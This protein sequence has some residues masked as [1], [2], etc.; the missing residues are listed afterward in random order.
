MADV[1]SSAQRATREVVPST[2]DAINAFASMSVALQGLTSALS[3]ASKEWESY[4]KAMR[5]VN[6]LFP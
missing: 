5:A 2:T 4:D 3:G 1:V 6:T